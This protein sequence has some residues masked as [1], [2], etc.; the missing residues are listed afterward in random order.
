V[1]Q[2]DER[3]VTFAELTVGVLDPGAGRHL[4]RRS[5]GVPDQRVRRAHGSSCL[6]VRTGTFHVSC[7]ARTGSAPWFAVPAAFHG[8]T[9]ERPGT[10]PGATVHANRDPVG[11]ATNDA[12]VEALPDASSGANV[13][14]F[15]RRRDPLA[16][17]SLHDVAF[18]LATADDFESAVARL[19]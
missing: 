10:F 19:A 11:M 5:P 12:L 13:I 7:S 16:R 9:R 1:L 14:D 8:P 3:H 18:A 4:L 15:P 17:D 2:Q 6:D